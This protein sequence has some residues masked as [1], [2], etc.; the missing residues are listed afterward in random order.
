M[1]CS[2]RKI[3]ISCKKLAGE[4]NC[5]TNIQFMKTLKL[6]APKKYLLFYKKSN[7]ENSVHETSVPIEETNKSIIC[8]SY[9]RGIRTFLKSN[10]VSMKEI[11]VSKVIV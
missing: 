4:T 10:I 8:Y 3:R 1:S 9:K 2:D 11:K 7:G 6:P 5:Q